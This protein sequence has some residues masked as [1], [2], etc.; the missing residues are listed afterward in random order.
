MELCVTMDNLNGQHFCSEESNPVVPVR[1]SSNAYTGPPQ[2]VTIHKSSST[3]PQPHEPLYF[4]LHT[5]FTELPL[6]NTLLAI[7]WNLYITSSDSSY[8]DCR[9]TP[10][11]IIRVSKNINTASLLVQI[12]PR[13]RG[14][15]CTKEPRAIT[16]TR[17]PWSYPNGHHPGG[18]VVLS[19]SNPDFEFKVHTKGL[20][21][22]E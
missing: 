19:S 18:T 11:S 2:L 15:L 10:N 6:R 20:A 13:Q 7:Y 3:K 1:V 16:H 5:S 9:T 8:T 14:Y 21:D 4:T 17:I 12:V 22:D